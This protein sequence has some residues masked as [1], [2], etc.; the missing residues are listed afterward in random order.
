MYSGQYQKPVRKRK[1]RKKPGIL[2]VSLVLLLAVVVGGSVA[3]LQDTTNQVENTFT[4]A[5]VEIDPTES[6]ESLD[7]EGYTEYTK[8]QISFSNPKDDDAVPVYIRATLVVYWSDMINGEEQVI[9]KPAGATITGGTVLGTD[10]FQVGDIYYYGNQVGPGAS[11]SV[12]LDTITVTIPDGS[13]AKCYIDVRAEAIQATPTTAVEEAW[14]DINV[15]G[16]TLE[17]AG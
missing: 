5:K 13:T 10:W 12:M 9:P 17:K 11:T 3:F 2:I 16:S 8:S 1:T 15:S 6:T 4:P 14:Q 7:E